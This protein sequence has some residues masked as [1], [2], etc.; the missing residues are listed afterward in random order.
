MKK[1]NLKSMLV[2]TV[3][4]LIVSLTYWGCTIEDPMADFTVHVAIPNS[5]TNFTVS[6]VDPATGWPVGLTDD[7]DVSIMMTGAGSGSIINQAYELQ[8][9]FTVS[10]GVLTF[11]LDDAV[12]PSTANPVS[13]TINADASGYTDGAIFVSVSDTGDY[14]FVVNMFN[15]AN[16]PSGMES[17]TNTSGSA[18]GGVVSNPISVTTGGGASGATIPAGTQLTTA[19]GAP[20]SGS[21]TT[22]IIYGSNSDPESMGAFPGGNQVVVNG[23]PSSFIVGAFM[24]MSIVDGSGNSA[25]SISDPLGLM[26]E[27]S[28]GT[29]NPNTGNPIQPGENIPLWGMNPSTGEWESAGSGVIGTA[30][31]SI[32]GGAQIGFPT[33]AQL[34]QWYNAICLAYQIAA[35]TDLAVSN[36]TANWMT[37]PI[38]MNYYVSALYGPGIYIPVQIFGYQMI[39][40]AMVNGSMLTMPDVPMNLPLQFQLTEVIPTLQIVHSQTITV[41]G[42]TITMPIVFPTTIVTTGALDLT[43]IGV[44]ESDETIEV[45]PSTTVNYIKSDMDGNPLSGYTPLS[46]QM[47]NGHMLVEGLVA[48]TL[49]EPSYYYFWAEYEGEVGD[50]V[51]SVLAGS[52]IV[53]LE[54]IIPEDIC[55]DLQ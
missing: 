54:L 14:T 49:N 20:L 52:N 25:G 50:T 17:G 43:M 9:N 33:V 46:Q 22:T 1:T 55:A 6:F 32:T 40:N 37:A 47:L 41:T 39:S 15:T 30:V 27:I 34:T 16:L 51:Y 42:G 23:S 2:L 35:T 8:T 7:T 28:T 44:C 18:S 12:T 13:F 21:L 31:N 4:L 26:M 36:S 19:S 45:R 48:G 10:S 24:N 53:N 11:A 5:N 3:G 38:Q 29:V